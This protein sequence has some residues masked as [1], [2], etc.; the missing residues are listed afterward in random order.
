MS[1]VSAAFCTTTSA[2]VSARSSTFASRWLFIPARC[3]IAPFGRPVEPEVNSTYAR[4]SPAPR[5]GTSSSG[6]Y[7]DRGQTRTCGPLSAVSARTRAA[8]ARAGG[9]GPELGRGAVATGGQIAE[10]A[11]QGVDAPHRPV[12]HPA[13]QPDT[14]RGQLAGQAA[15]PPRHLGVG[16]R[17][18]VIGDG[19][20]VRT[21]HGQFAH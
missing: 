14:R 19:H 20:R 13:V 6:P 12:P 1:N 7:P 4:S 9:G 15:R 8:S 18:F 11:T 2:P 3:T 21:A 17:A 5:R 16:D 10:L